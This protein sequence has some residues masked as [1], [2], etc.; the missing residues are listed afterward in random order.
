MKEGDVV[1][2]VVPQFDEQTKNRPVI[3]L[4]EMPRFRDLLV[5]GHQRLLGTLSRYLKPDSTA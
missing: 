3:V 1:L 2:A 4:R 5:C